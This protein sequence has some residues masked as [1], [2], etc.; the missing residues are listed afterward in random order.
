MAAA[1]GG[2]NVAP[3]RNFSEA[4]RMAGRDTL[5]HPGALATLSRLRWLSIAAQVLAIVLVPR[6]LP[7][8]LPWLPMAGGV[9][10]LLA[11]N[12]W[13][14]SRARRGAGGSVLLHLGVDIAV[15]AWQLYWSG[16]PANPFVSLFIVPIALATA[17]LP[18][19]AVL[20]TALMAVL[21]YGLLWLDHQPLPHVHGEF[22]LHLLGMW[23]NFLLT[24]AVL[25]FFGTRIASELARQRAALA[26]ERERSVR[27][28]G[29]LAVATLAAGAAHAIN[30][31]LATL[32]VVLSDLRDGMAGMDAAA[33]Q[34]DVALMSAQVEACRAAVGQL[35][36]DARSESGPLAA[37][38]LDDRL[39]AAVERW[40][41]LRPGF[42]ARLEFS[43]DAGDLALA[44]DRSFDYLVLN[45]LDNAADASR[46]AGSDGVV[47]RVSRE[48]AFLR[49][50][51][52]DQGPGLAGTPSPLRSD[53]PGGL[54]LGFALATRVC[55]Q[56]D[57]ALQPVSGGVLARLSLARLAA[58]A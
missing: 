28:E 31:P 40:R 18:A 17:L 47:L 46:S 37:G 45:L 54:G 30:T 41:L 50:T 38:R 9:A 48:P 22:D 20:A 21:A 51:F 44:A 6:L 5:S 23:L 32:S 49:M 14:T 24:A 56:F 3:M 11:F 35:I 13:V 36:S 43:D 52:L 16:G 34:E 57:G 8:H 12:L 42:D 10:L 25:A 26:A 15:L 2:A 55:E 53:K 58:A 39:H 27:D 29:L 4:S 19:R 33:L 7:L 1:Q